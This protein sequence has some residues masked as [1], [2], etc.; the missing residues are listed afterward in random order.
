[1]Q[2]RLIPLVLTTEQAN[3]LIDIWEALQHDTNL[4]ENRI[5]NA[6]DIIEWLRVSLIALGKPTR[7]STWDRVRQDL[8]I[9]LKTKL[10]RWRNRH[11]VITVRL[12]REER[13]ALL[14]M[15]EL[16]KS[17]E[18]LRAVIEKVRL[19]KEV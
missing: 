12:T 16:Q 10:L 9:H 8:R 14:E 3:A 6:Y 17:R 19:A 5:Q 18:E 15:L 4:S 1:M 2:S 11:A 13:I 7:Y